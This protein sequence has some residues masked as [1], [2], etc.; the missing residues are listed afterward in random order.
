MHFVA[1]EYDSED[2]IGKIDFHFLTLDE[3]N[4]RVSRV[5]FHVWTQVVVNNQPFKEINISPIFQNSLDVSRL[6]E[7]AS[8]FSI[9]KTF[10]HHPRTKRMNLKSHPIYFTKCFK[11]N[12]LRAI[13]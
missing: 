9:L 6:L 7:C 10:Y 13:Y 1:T 5:L 2:M 12:S 8:N 3:L 11:P 4:T